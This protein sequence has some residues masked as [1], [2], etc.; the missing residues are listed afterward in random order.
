VSEAELQA[1]R[2]RLRRARV[3][4][5]LSQEALAERVG[6]TARTVINWET[7]VNSPELAKIPKIAA[8]TGVKPAWFFAGEDEEPDPLDSA[9][10]NGKLDLVLQVLRDQGAEIR[11][12]A[13]LIEANQR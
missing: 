9:E 1:F 8:A 2:Q 11:R 7:G 6:V 13:D 4:E 10:V 3:K 12:L 5:G